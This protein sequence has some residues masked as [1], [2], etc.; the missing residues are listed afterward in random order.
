MFSN[1]EK[2]FYQIKNAL[3]NSADLKRLVFYNTADA[4]IRAEPTY[5]E[6]ESSIYLK[7]VIYVYD[8]SPEKGISSFIS[9][10]LIESIILDGSISSS[11]KI[12][13]ACDREIWVLNEDRI[14]PLAILS[15]IANKLDQAKFEA[16]GKLNLRVVKEIYYNNDL[17]G[18]TALFDIDDEKGSVVNEF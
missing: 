16:A 12:S 11:I 14:R 9:I 4:L 8:D 18:Y 2:I 5:A 7:P 15:E 10:G 13:V 17:V 3:L 6:A 1:F